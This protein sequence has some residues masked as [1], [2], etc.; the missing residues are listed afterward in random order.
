M[1]FAINDGPGI[2]TTVFLKGCPLSCRWCHNPESQSYEPEV[3]YSS[4]RCVSCRSCCDACESGA[5]QWT[6]GPV[7]NRSLC[8]LCAKCMEACPADARKLIGKPVTVQELMQVIS[9]DRVFFEE[10]GGGVT[11]S[12]GEPLSQPE[13]LELALAACRAAA[14]STAVD[15]SGYVSKSVLTRIG[16]LT[17]DFL[18]DLKMMDDTKHRYYVGVSNERILENLALLA[19]EH[20]NVTVRIPIIPGINDDEANIDESCKF[21]AA[22][23]LSRVDLLPFHETAVEKYKRLNA[24]YLLAGTK[25][26]SADHVL[27]I[28][29]RFTKQGFAVRIGG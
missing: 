25:P 8:T 26:P 10:S 16:K 19:Q 18:F 9:R 7:R 17:D 23:H 21:L 22:N 4:D 13:F 29:D 15:T 5:L 14:L 11:F 20:P 12:G 24:E 6:D 1:R 3:A 27:Q 28:A 2:R